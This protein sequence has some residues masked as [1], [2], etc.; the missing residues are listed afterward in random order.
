M[1]FLISIQYPIAIVE[2]SEKANFTFNDLKI[3]LNRWLCDDNAES[4]LN[5]DNPKEILNRIILWIDAFAGCENR[6][7]VITDLS[8]YDIQKFSNK[9][10]IFI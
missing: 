7:K 5:G 4:I 2:I 1:R 8:D 9:E 10:T 6:I 3:A